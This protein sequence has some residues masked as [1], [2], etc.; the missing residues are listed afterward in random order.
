MTR[1]RRFVTWAATTLVV[2]AL[3]SALTGAPTAAVAA[4][5]AQE[6]GEP[7]VRI[8][9]DRLTPDIPAD[10]DVLRITGRVIS[11]VDVA[12]SDISVQ[13]RRSSQPAS[14]RGQIVAIHDA[15]LEPEDGEPTDVPLPGT[16]V[17]VA[18]Q[19]PAG[20]RRPFSIRVPITQLGFTAPGSYPLALEALGREP[21]VDEFD[22]RKGIVRTFLPWFPDEA[23]VV[24]IQLVWL[25]PLS[26]WPD[27]AADGTLLSNR[28]PEEL[29][30][31]GRLERLL[32]IGT[33]HRAT[34][35]WIADPALLQTASV[36][37]RGYE[38]RQ[39]G[40][41]T[42]GDQDAA[43]ERWLVGLRTATQDVGL[44][45]LPYA[46]VD[47]SALT[48]GDLS[49][50][51]VRAVTQGPGLASAALG[52]AVPGNLYWAPFG[53]IDRPALNVLAS[54]GVTSIILSAGAMP[55]TDENAS[56]LGLATAALPTSL[57]TIKAVLTDPGLTA[58]LGLPQR[59]A[60]DVIRARQRFLAETATIAQTIP[61][62]QASRVL[63]VAPDSVRWT[64]TASLVNPLLR[65]TRSASWLEPESMADL[66]DAPT[67]S[68]S[69]QR[70]GYGDKAR[71]AEL[72]QNYVSR[73][74]RVSHELDVFT[75]AL[76]DPTGIVQPFS[77]ALLRAESAA[78]RSEPARGSEL[79]ASVSEGIQAE[80]SRVRV[81]SEGQVTLSGDVGKVPVTIT[82][83][84]DR[85]VTV[86]LVLRGVPPLRLSAAPL[87]GIR[88]EPG[89]FAS[90]DIEARVVG[91]E[92][93][94][95]EVQ[96]L[97]PDGDDY[98]SPARI[99]VVS[100]AY[101]RAASWVV[102]IAFLAIVVFVIV[103]V[104][105]RIHGAS[106]SRKDRVDE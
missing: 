67:P 21:G 84:L 102:G 12:L 97:S 15:G 33:R 34:L 29:A 92:P 1:P 5:P 17:Q 82:N 103:G 75:S 104:T 4:L 20:A 56:T 86:G 60:S 44:R 89:A 3:A 40:A 93:L 49:N 46:D 2:G 106:T 95:V 53:R 36:M 14:T 85:S 94:P 63:V 88:I 65:A 28:T 19:L 42:V 81:L 58:V 76:D 27:R 64:A 91:G 7:S 77:E 96:L 98:G 43:A 45:A 69:R 79:L 32:A 54:A 11:D 47:A 90:V 68:T 22:A 83:E 31:G 61:A 13:L 8:V 87:T 74:A 55:A 6:E 23:E 52:A 48:R 18:D 16:R 35:S 9:I 80:I 73:I 62:D 99:T 38:V 39:D 70:G 59:S 41:I 57:G 25:W 50:D 51:V 66:L 78:W 24:P 10:D 26:D 105:R 37:S 30:D 101:A 72:T 100:T 71:E